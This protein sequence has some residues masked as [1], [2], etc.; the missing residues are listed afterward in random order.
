MSR[1]PAGCRGLSASIAWVTRTR[2]A[3]TFVLPKA[4]ERGSDEHVR[5]STAFNKKLG[6]VGATVASV[7]FTTAGV[8]VGLRRRR[9]KL[10]SVRLGR[11]GRL[12]PLRAPLA[13]PGSGRVEAVAES[14]DPTP[15]LPG[16]WAGAHGGRAVG[17]SRSSPQPRRARRGGVHGPADGQDRRSPVC[18][19]SAGK[20][21]PGSS[22]TSS[23]WLRRS[24][25][26]QP[27][28]QRSVP[29][30]SATCRQPLPDPSEPP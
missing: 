23:P 2:R 30:L 9:S 20:R 17:P 5:V 15:S 6:I 14:R 3:P 12:R 8:V 19:G 21:S 1:A 25:A 4:I 10:V 18:C 7:T 26:A 27:S 29:Q 13:A 24:V 16:L 28:C 11:H 22:S